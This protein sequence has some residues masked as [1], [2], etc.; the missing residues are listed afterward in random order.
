[1]RIGVQEIQNPAEKIQ[2]SEPADGEEREGGR[3]EAGPR[4]GTLTPPLVTPAWIRSS[5]TAWVGS[6]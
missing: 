5:S 1:M 2:V 4:K 3:A 6:S